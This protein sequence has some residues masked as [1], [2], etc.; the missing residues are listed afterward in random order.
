MSP[1]RLLAAVL[2]FVIAGP[3]LGALTV[4]LAG[5]FLALAFGDDNGMAGL[6]FYSALLAV[7]VSWLFGGLQAAFAGLAFAAVAAVRGRPA[8][9]VAVAAGVF[10]GVMYLHR[11][12]LDWPAYGVVL[13]GHVV[14]AATCGAIGKSMLRDAAAPRSAVSDRDRIG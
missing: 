5:S 7:P 13:L 9:S 14:A 10:G 2:V 3:P 4:S 1:S 6:V 12:D 8:I 11:G